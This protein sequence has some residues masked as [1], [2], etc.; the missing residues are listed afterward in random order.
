M[1]LMALGAM[2]D[3]HP[4]SL[5]MLGHPLQLTAFENVNRDPATLGVHD[6]VLQDVVALEEL[7]LAD[8]VRPSR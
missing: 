3:D 5:G 6:P 7:A 2:P 4:L 1:T 8:L